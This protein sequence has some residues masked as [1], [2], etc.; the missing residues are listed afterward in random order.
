MKFAGEKVLFSKVLP[1]PFVFRR[2]MFSLTCMTWRL[3]NVSHIFKW[4]LFLH[5]GFTQLS[6]FKTTNGHNFEE[7]KTNL[8]PL[9]ICISLLII[10]SSRLFCWITTLV[11]CWSFCVVGLEWYP[12]CRLVLQP[13]TQ[14]PLQPNHTETPTNIEPRTIRPM[15]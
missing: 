10:R 13:A 3:Q 6:Q 4:L 15:W 14:I 9:V 8:M 5:F 12:C 11:V 2:F 7:L 1:N